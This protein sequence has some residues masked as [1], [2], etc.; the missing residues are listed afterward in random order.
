VRS[1]GA[2]GAFDLL[3]CDCDGVIVDSEIICERVLASHLRR[4]YPGR[5]VA[6]GLAGSFGLQTPAILDRLVAHLGE[7]L[8]V[9]FFERLDR[10]LEEALHR[11]A[12]AISGVHEALERIELPVAV[13][14]NSSE[15]WVRLCLARAG[16]L[17]RVDGR[18]FTA[19]HVPNPKPAPDVFLLAAQQ[20]GVEPARCLAIEDSE[21]G[22]AAALAAGMPVIGFV[23]ASHIPRDHGNR[24]MA[25]G[26]RQVVEHMARLP[27]AVM[28]LHRGGAAP[29]A[30]TQPAQ[31]SPPPATTASNRAP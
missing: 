15:A 8:P 28:S 6:A 29:S 14:S 9:G 22:L 11:E 24:L 31:A 13:A 19:D 3:I 20:S 26:A 2:E 18:I 27:A 17:D 21:T 4:A 1:R 5:D 7:P 25:L 10:E 12:E 16:L 23:G 30:G